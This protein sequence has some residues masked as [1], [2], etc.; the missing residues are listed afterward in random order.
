MS[1]FNLARRALRFAWSETLEVGRSVPSRR[2]D[3]D[4]SVLYCLRL[5]FLI[6]GLLVFG[7]QASATEIQVQLS[8]QSEPLK[9]TGVPFLHEKPLEAVGDADGLWI[10]GVKPFQWSHIVGESGAVT[11]EVQADE[12]LFDE[13]VF[14]I[15]NWHN[16]AIGQWKIAAG[17]SQAFGI[18]IEGR[19]VYLFT[20]DG[21]KDGE[22]LK[23][24]NRSIAM[25]EDLNRVRKTWKRDEFFLGICAFPGRYHW[26]FKGVPTL[27]SQLTEEE[28]REVEA[29]LLARLGFQVVRTDESMEMGQRISDGGERSFQFDFTRMDNAVEAYTSRGFELA[30]QL[31]NAPD[32]GVLPKYED[33]PKPLWRYPREEVVQRAYVGALLDRYGKHA[34]FLQVFNE[35]DQKAF[36]AGTQEEYL[37]Q[38]EF[39]RNEIHRTRPGMLV[40]NGGYSLVDQSRTEFFVNELEGQSSFAAYHSHGNIDDLAEDFETMK[41]LQSEAGYSPVRLMNTEM[42]C[43]GWRL[44]Q[45]RRKGQIVPQKTLFCWANDHAGVLLFGGRMTL[46]PNRTNQDFGFLDHYFCPRPVY[47]TMAGLIAT[48]DGASFVRSRHDSGGVYLYE[49]DKKGAMILAAFTTGDEAAFELQT[50]ASQLVQIDEMGNRTT[51]EVNGGLVVELGGYPK[52]LEFPPGTGFSINVR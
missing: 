52:Y 49:F 32:W 13:G 48:L 33:E 23:R 1:V 41:R 8:A 31:M 44:D 37:T 16:K 20:L 29:D 17:S 26:S 50:D 22:C 24:L 2:F 36:W 18:E 25:T 7:I 4:Q 47:G 43:D 30:L 12:K 27:P 14:T 10:R 6:P 40:V 11:L 34:R 42:G 19:G 28:A 9:V 21:Y 39:T 35:P 3:I 51:L 46:G 15:W 38:F 45:E 5:A